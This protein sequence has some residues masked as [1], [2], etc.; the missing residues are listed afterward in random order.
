M[1]NNLKCKR[2]FTLFEIL[3]VLALV[4]LLSVLTLVDFSFLDKV[5]SRPANKQLTS[6]IKRAQAEAIST[7]TEVAIFYDKAL[8]TLFLKDYKTS[9]D[10]FKLPL[11]KDDIQRTAVNRN[12]TFKPVYPESIN[13][14]VSD[15]N[16]VEFLRSLRF[17][18]DGTSV[19][20]LILI[21][22][23]GKTETYYL[24]SFASVPVEQN[25]K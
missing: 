25:A 2:A 23:F 21:E 12:I 1:Q 8:D 19:R 5:E 10:I 20:A 16:R 6:L 9:K 11:S 13:T 15:I 22:E 4:A 18:P 3:A 14:Y 17:Y 24:D 7:S